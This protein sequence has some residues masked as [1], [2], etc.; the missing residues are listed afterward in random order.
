[1]I[2]VRKY[3]ARLWLAAALVCLHSG[4]VFAQGRDQEVAVV[5]HFWGFDGRVHPGHFNPLSILIDNETS[6]GADVVITLQP[7]DG[8]D[9][10]RAVLQ[11]KVFIAATARRWIQFYPYVSN[12]FQKEWILKIDGE[13]KISITQARASIGEKETD[14]VPP[15]AVLIVRSNEWNQIRGTGV[16]QFPENVFPPYASATTALHTV[17]L[18]HNPDWEEPRQQAFLSWLR[19]GGQLNLLE[20]PGGSLPV[21]TGAMADLNRPVTRYAYGAGLVQQHS[22]DRKTLTPEA[23]EQMIAA[24]RPRLTE[25]QREEGQLE[26]ERLERQGLPGDTFQTKDPSMMDGTIF[27]EMRDLTRPEH[28]WLL[29]FPLAM[30]Y[31]GLIFPGCYVLSKQK[32]RHFLVT[33]GAIIGLA[34]LFS[35]LFL[36]IGRRGYGEETNLQSLV[37]ARAES[38]TTWS[39]FQWSS[40]FVTGGAEYKVSIP[41]QQAVSQ[42]IDPSGHS[43]TTSV[44]GKD[45][46]ITMQIPPFSS[47]SFVTR[48][49]VTLADW[50]LKLNS[51]NVNQDRINGLTLGVGPNLPKGEGTS[52]WAVYANRVHELRLDTKTSQLT[53]LGRGRPMSS[54]VLQFNAYS[55]DTYYY[56]EVDDSD[57]RSAQEK[58]YDKV[59]HLLVQRSLVDDLVTSELQ[60]GLPPDRVRLLVFSRLSPEFAIELDAEASKTGR[61]LYTRDLLRQDFQTAN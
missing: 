41:D 15:Q 1:M 58:F 13:K 30:A 42:T 8:L 28:N 37:V 19:R 27:R 47:Q 26:L 34:T 59:L 24:R 5:E 6:D 50:E 46:E 25:A 52:Y 38:S 57:N 48:R 53:L 11:Q 61:I 60:S 43:F 3:Q 31:I 22:Y 2:S 33:Y 44:V 14:R 17:F 16:K 21:F 39:A 7:T 45:A 36:F 49:Q 20:S 18:D 54:F 23:V 55:I 56:G 32:Q 40:L 51:I 29:I 10:S 4:A 9:E 35:G 12:S